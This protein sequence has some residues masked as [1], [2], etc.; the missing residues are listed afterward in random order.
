MSED[1]YI[2][3]KIIMWG[4]DVEN[5]GVDDSDGVMKFWE[6]KELFEMDNPGETPIIARYSIEDDHEGGEE[7]IH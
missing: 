5:L 1:I 4:E 2:L 7:V 3:R 6:S